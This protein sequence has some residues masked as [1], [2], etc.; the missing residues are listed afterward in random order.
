MMKRKEGGGKEGCKE[1]GGETG[2][3]KGKELDKKIVLCT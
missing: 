3:G 2:G 1:E